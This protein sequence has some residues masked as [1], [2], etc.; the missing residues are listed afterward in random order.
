MAKTRAKKESMDKQD[1]R[2]EPNKRTLDDIMPQWKRPEDHEAQLAAEMTSRLHALCT[3]KKNGETG[4]FL[5]DEEILKEILDAL[6]LT[7]YEQGQ[8]LV[9][10]YW[11]YRR[12]CKDEAVPAKHRKR[13]AVDCMRIEIHQ[14]LAPHEIY[15]LEKECKS[16]IVD[17]IT[18]EDSAPSKSR[19]T[20]RQQSRRKRYG[21]S[22][23]NSKQ[24][25]N[26]KKSSANA[27]GSA[28]ANAGKQD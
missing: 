23:S 19:N 9:K 6:T 16:A 25:G 20:G 17:L 11:M 8:A 22:G 13:Y 14:C 15:K 5:N 18:V 24:T 2:D 21:S 27:G 3:K 1:D 12:H 10:R 4:R 28:S 7:D 26:N